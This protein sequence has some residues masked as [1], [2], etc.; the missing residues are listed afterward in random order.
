[1][2]TSAHDLQYSIWAGG[3]G[4]R[5]PVLQRGSPDT[6][7]ACAK[8]SEIKGQKSQDC[9]P[10]PG[11]A[12]GG[13]PQPYKL[14]R[15]QRGP[16]EKKGDTP[17]SASG[18]HTSLPHWGCSRLLQ[19][20]Q[21]QPEDGGTGAGDNGWNCVSQMGGVPWCSGQ[22]G[23]NSGRGGT[24]VAGIERPQTVHDQMCSTLPG[25]GKPRLSL[26]RL[27]SGSRRGTVVTE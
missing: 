13:G 15:R 6:S 4:S 16:R 14:P 9:V 2:T 11:T 1:M 27:P 10:Y 19:F 24:A 12:N 22:D 21:Y 18:I 3:T 5:R 23:V 17:W 7:S 20:K 26:I 8:P 25:K